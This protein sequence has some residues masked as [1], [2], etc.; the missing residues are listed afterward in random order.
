MT[1]NAPPPTLDPQ[2]VQR[3]WPA[4]VWRRVKTVPMTV[5]V[6]VVL[7]L[8]LGA[9]A[10]AAEVIRPESTA[11]SASDLDE[12]AAAAVGRP[13]PGAVDNSGVPGP[14]P[15]STGGG[16]EVATTGG[17]VTLS[18]RVEAEGKP[19]DGARVQL[20][21]W[22][23][24]QS[25]SVVLDA[26]DEGAFVGEGLVGGLWTITAW[27]QP[28]YR[29][30]DVQRVFMGEGQAATLTLRPPIVDAVAIDAEA[31]PSTDD[32]QTAVVV[33][34]T[35][36]VVDDSGEVVGVGANGT[37]T[38]VYPSGHRGPGEVAITDGQGQFIVQC[39]APAVGGR[40]TITFDDLDV[41]VELPGCQRRTTTTSPGPPAPTV[42]TSLPAGP[43][44]TVGPGRR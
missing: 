28:Q 32:N 37:A 14:A 29:R 30:T 25:A 8:A 12:R 3:S 9:V 7:A 38:I 44:T 36:Q 11:A 5:W 18:G 4:R 1:T 26:N 31:G 39:V 17:T 23:G 33:V 10:I 40:V 43:T 16:L 24:E 13:L 20:T 15:A 34:A 41:Q 42:P 19:L 6:V 21:R 2:P 27:K 35:A 22:V